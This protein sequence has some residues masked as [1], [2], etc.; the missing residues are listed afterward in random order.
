MKKVDIH[1]HIMPPTWELLHEKFGYKGFIQLEEEPATGA[2]R[3]MRDDGVFFRRV[4]RN[5]YDP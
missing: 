5:C 3:M 1:A 2:K 4:E